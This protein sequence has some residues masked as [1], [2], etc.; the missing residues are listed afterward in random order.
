MYEMSA[1]KNVK[2]KDEIMRAQW[3]HS[4]IFEKNCYVP[5]IDDLYD[6][7]E[8]KILFVGDVKKIG[9][10][11]AVA[12][13]NQRVYPKTSLCS[14]SIDNNVNFSKCLKEK[15]P[16][17]S[18]VAFAYYNFF[19]DRLAGAKIKTPAPSGTDLDVY[20]RAFAT[21]Y[22]ALAPQKVV[23]FGKQVL[24]VLKR[25]TRPVAFDGKTIE[26]FIGEKK[27]EC[28][29]LNGSNDEVEA[30]SELTSCVTKLGDVM[31]ILWNV[32]TSQN[33]GK[34]KFFDKQNS[35]DYDDLKESDFKVLNED[36]IKIS[37]AKG[38]TTKILLKKDSVVR[39][40]KTRQ[41]YLLFKSLRTISKVQESCSRISQLMGRK[42]NVKIERYIEYFT[43]MVN[44]L[45]YYKLCISR[46]LIETFIDF[47]E[48]KW[49]TANSMIVN[50]DLENNGIDV[51]VKD[52]DVYLGKIRN[53]HNDAL[54]KGETKSREY[55]N[56]TKGYY[57]KI[58]FMYSY[59][60]HHSDPN[61]KKLASVMKER[62]FLDKG[63][64]I[65]KLLKKE[66][67]DGLK[68]DGKIIGKWK[69]K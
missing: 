4:N 27:Y 65:L 15:C 14:K 13:K 38:S 18:N 22:K 49:N 50:K 51:K 47:V 61:I 12:Q 1:S 62:I 52:F 39:D 2:I 10:N 11:Q 54:I 55:I 19:F 59:F 35:I 31:S 26:E 24:R 60:Y 40:F 20:L 69:P 46:D 68:K 36:D 23:F 42:K 30:E 3:E 44:F 64:T 57:K 41:D 6:A 45:D 17:G 21:V 8:E 56:K 58:E 28:F 32:L 53:K 48:M 34:N 5:Y 25:T 7:S 63:G 16:S 29:P 66:T 43:F 67:Y 9:D 33:P 37:F